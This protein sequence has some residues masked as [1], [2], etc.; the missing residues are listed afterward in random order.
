MN[1]A[2]TDPGL[3]KFIIDDSN[4][5]SFAA[6]VKDPNSPFNGG[7]NSDQ[8]QQG[9]GSPFSRS[10]IPRREW[11]DHIKRQEA[12][13]S[14][15][16]HWRLRGGVPV[17]DQNGYGYC[18]CYGTVGA[19]MNA[20]AQTGMQS[21]HLSAMGPAWQG[22]RGR[23]EGGWAGEA[24]GYIEK[25]GIPELSVWPEHD[26]NVNPNDESVKRSAAMHGH[27]ETEELERNNFEA[28]VSALLDPERPTACTIGLQWWGHLIYATKA[29]EIS[30]GKFGVKIVN[31]WKKSWGKDGCSVLAENKA[32][33]FEQIAVVRVKPRVAA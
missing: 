33:A 11:S 1:L 26:K 14:S 29:V 8:V 19:I 25:Y 10:I 22:K 31:S 27:V 32:I 6:E 4:A 13:K 20:Y 30:P 17:L 23:N 5:S 7:F 15:P 28:L 24:L 9:F 12:E 21:P 2:I 18:W 16:D 3:E